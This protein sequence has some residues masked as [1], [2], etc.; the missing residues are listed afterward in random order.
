MGRILLLY[1][2]KG[3]C[4]QMQFPSDTQ[5]YIPYN[6]VFASSLFW[7]YISLSSLF[8]LEYAEFHRNAAFWYIDKEQRGFVWMTNIL[9]YFKS[10]LGLLAIGAHT[11]SLEAYL[12]SNTLSYTHMYFQN[13]WYTFKWAAY[14]WVENKRKA[15]FKLL[16]SQIFVTL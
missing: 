11:Q 5:L 7:F 9:L 4:F 14:K 15:H 8:S 1:L 12:P 6:F 3:R 10:Q 13:V 2:D 16:L